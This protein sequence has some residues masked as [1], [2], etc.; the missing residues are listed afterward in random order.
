M[1]YEEMKLLGFLLLI[2]DGKRRTRLTQTK[3]A[4]ELGISQQSVSRLLRVLEEK[5]YI[6][7]I[8]K[9]RGEYIEITDTAQK[10]IEQIHSMTTSIL[11]SDKDKLL[12]EG[13][14]IS[15]LGEGRYYMSIKYYSEMIKKLMGFKAYPGTL[16][17]RLIGESILKRKELDGRKGLVIPSFRTEKR[18][19]GGAR[20][21]PCKINGYK[22]AGIIIPDRTS[23][24]KE[25]IEVIAPEYLRKVLGV[26]DGDKVVIE[27][28][29]DVEKI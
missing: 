5:G 3:T 16:N 20:L 6:V 24:G 11:A 12:L 8:V 27:V 15:G 10:L 17:I 1:K 2:M 4:E 14:V 7:R 18:V 26:K 21:F 22:P 29:K 23:H 13:I 25:I 9:G 19:Y 28:T